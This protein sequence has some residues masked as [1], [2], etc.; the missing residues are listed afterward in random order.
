MTTEDRKN[1]VAPCGIDCGLCEAYTCKDDRQLFSYL[2]SMGISQEKI[3]CCGCRTI[4]GKCPIIGGTCATYACITERKTEF[5]FECAEFPCSRL[6][7]SADRA[8]VLPH[9]LKV[10]N[11][12]TIQRKGVE[13]FIE[14]ST[15][16]KKRYYKGKMEIGKGPQVE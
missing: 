5:C 13:G 6:N 14:R 3:P 15:E 11:L 7:P 16:F 4:E 9:N 10:F 12:C 8:D 2:V 1:L